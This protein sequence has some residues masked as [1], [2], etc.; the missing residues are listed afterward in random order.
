MNA[1]I[2]NNSDTICAIST[3][4]GVGGIAVIR[5][6]GKKTLPIVQKIWR[7]ARLDDMKSHTA[8]LGKIVE[9]GSGDELDQAVLTLF[10]GP[11]SFTGEDVV[12]LSVHGSEWIQ[13]MVLQTLVDAGARPA[14]PGEFTRRA[15]LHGRLD[16]VE[17]E[18]VGDLIASNSR[19]AHRLAMS[20][21]KGSFSARIGSLRESLIR[22]ASLMELEL[23]FAEEE[24]EFASR[25]NLRQ[26]SKDII[27]EIEKLVASFRSGNAIKNGIPIA[28][29]GATNAGKSSLLNRLLQEERAIVSNIHGT[30]RDV[31]EDT[32][33][34][35]DYLV[36]LKDTAGLR[37]T[38]DQ[39]EQLGIQRSHLEAERASVVLF[40]VDATD[41]HFPTSETVDDR[42]IFIINKRDLAKTD[43]LE[44]SIRSRFPRNVILT[45]TT[46]EETDIENVRQQLAERLHAEAGG[47][48][49]VTVTNVRHARALSE[50]ADH[51]RTMLANMGAGIPTDLLAQD[52]R[53]A[54][55]SLS[56][57][58][59]QITT[60]DLLKTIFESFCI[61][62]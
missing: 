49:D 2:Y 1:E 50:A 38:N 36:R 22:L 51:L 33:T 47:E 43:K 10:R 20:Q 27:S 5:V 18:A 6:S 61:G 53:A 58:T 59:G 46:N 32:I 11:N 52:L 12:E 62:K 25:D 16:L 26:L 13:S 37:A 7:G 4:R 55:N 8:H 44:N 60:P 15:Y 30:T 34:I 21:L 35:G 40:V 9:Q 42:Y 24:V 39:I 28:I 29:L 54:I 3:P 41:P 56:S 45:I 14:L 19:A 17:A 57:I 31:I 23:D 48:P